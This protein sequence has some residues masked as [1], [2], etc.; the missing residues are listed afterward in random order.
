M[1]TDKRRG[2]VWYMRDTAHKPENTK[3]L[4][5][6]RP[7]VIVSSDR[8]N[9]SGSLVLVIPLSSSPAQLARGEGT[10]DMVRI[11]GYPGVPSMVMPRQ[12]HAVDAADLDDYWYHLSDD[13]M[14]RVDDALHR[15]LGI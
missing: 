6:D 4:R 7:V 13:D 3:L 2:D 12:I 10:F 11:T 5:G 15:T 8:V 9:Q 1:F 14:R